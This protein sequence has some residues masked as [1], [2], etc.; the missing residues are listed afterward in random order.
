MQERWGIGT[1]LRHAPDRGGVSEGDVRLLNRTRTEALRDGAGRNVTRRQNRRRGRTSS[2]EK[3]DQWQLPAPVWEVRSCRDADVRRSGLGSVR[4]SGERVRGYRAPF[5]RPDVLLH[6]T[7]GA[8]GAVWL[9]SAAR[10]AQV[11]E[12]QRAIAITR[13]TLR[14]GASFQVEHWRRSGVSYSAPT[15]APPTAT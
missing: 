2:R 9:A 15:L 11:P 12:H 5:F 10:T 7:V 3:N 4:S 6:I 1:T 13:R 14:R 8:Y